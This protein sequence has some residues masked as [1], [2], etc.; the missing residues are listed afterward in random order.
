MFNDTVFDNILY[1]NPNKTE[2]DVIE[3]CKKL[4]LH[5]VIMVQTQI[6]YLK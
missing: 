6:I 5:E 3:I 1:A 4:N 2:K